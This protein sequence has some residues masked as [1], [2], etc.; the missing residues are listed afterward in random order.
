MRQHGVGRHTLTSD[1]TSMM[2]KAV[3]ICRFGRTGRPAGR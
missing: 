1:T 3:R 2:Q